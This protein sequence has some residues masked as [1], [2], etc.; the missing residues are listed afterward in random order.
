MSSQKLFRVIASTSYWA[1]QSGYF[2]SF[3]QCD[4]KKVRVWGPRDQIP[5]FQ[6]D[7]RSTIVQFDHNS[8]I[9]GSM[10]F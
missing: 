2:P 5:C 4:P 9:S 10:I 1:G 8:G 6:N 7:P 3:M